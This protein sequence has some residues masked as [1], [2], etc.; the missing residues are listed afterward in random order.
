MVVV[1]VVVLISFTRWGKAGLL[2]Q[3]FLLLFCFVLFFEKA[4]SFTGS[5]FLYS[6]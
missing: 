2:G 1:V 6:D 4:R 5:L 3:F